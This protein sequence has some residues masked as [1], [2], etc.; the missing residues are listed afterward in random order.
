MT[1]IAVIED[2]AGLNTGIVLALKNETF[3]FEQYA[4]LSEAEAGSYKNVKFEVYKSKWIV[5]I[6]DSAS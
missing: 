3:Q 4:S 6:Y 1:R 5:L 2:D